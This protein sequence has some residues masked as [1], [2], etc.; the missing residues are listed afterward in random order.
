MR[1]NAG[2]LLALAAGLTL[3]AATE[4]KTCLMLY[5]MADNNLEYYLRQ[6]YEELTKS[7]V[8]KSGDLRL[9]TYYDALNQGGDPLPN[10]LGLD[11]KPLTDK[12]TGSRYMTYDDSIGSMRV[13]VELSGEQNSDTRQVIEDFLVHAM[14]DCKAAGYTSLMGIFSSHGGGFAGYGGDENYRRLLRRYGGAPEDDEGSRKL[15]QTNQGIVKAITNALA[16]TGSGDKLDVIGFDACLMQAVG[17]ADDYGGVARNIL[18][19]EAV[20]PGHGKC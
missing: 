2:N 7:E 6:D 14:T 3:P 1:L 9:W 19:S 11:G 17:A 20:E 15:L 8:I 12:F 18:A 16:T 13:D 10:T 4:A 5:Q